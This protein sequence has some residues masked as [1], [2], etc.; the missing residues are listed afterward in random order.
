VTRRVDDVP[1][2]ERALLIESQVSARTLAALAAGLPAELDR[3]EV[4]LF[5]GYTFADIPLG[6]TFDCC[7]AAGDETS[8][9]WSDVQVVAGSQQFARPWQEIP[10]GWSTIIVLRFAP[11]IPDLVAALPI[12]DDWSH[13]PTVLISTRETWTARRAMAAK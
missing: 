7:F 10:H 4:A 13:S 5:A 1:V 11:E 6:T 8:V 2:E 3:D 9:R 12:A